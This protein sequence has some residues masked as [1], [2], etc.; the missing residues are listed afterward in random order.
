[1]ENKTFETVEFSLGAKE[2]VNKIIF[3][4]VEIMEDACKNIDEGKDIYILN[5]DGNIVKIL[6]QMISSK[7]YDGTIIIGARQT[8]GDKK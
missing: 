3:A 2:N 6:H 7:I 4:N 1:M 5:K 8:K